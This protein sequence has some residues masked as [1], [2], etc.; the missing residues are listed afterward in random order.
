MDIDFV[1]L[2]ISL[3]LIIAFIA[4][5]YI[6]IRKNHRVLQA[7]L[8]NVQNFAR[9][10]R[11][12]LDEQAIWRNRYFIELDKTKKSLIFTNDMRQTLPIMVD[13]PSIRGVK[14]LENFHYVKQNG[15]KTKVIDNLWLQLFTSDGL[16]AYSMEFY[17]GNLYSDLQGEAVMAKEWKN[18]VEDLIVKTTHKAMVS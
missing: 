9:Q 13:I 11:L 4:P 12:K 5:I 3:V 15:Q 10:Q 14:I 18:R 7:G 6:N 8:F 1:S 16:P 17:D 2:G